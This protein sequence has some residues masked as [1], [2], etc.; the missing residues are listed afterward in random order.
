MLFVDYVHCAYTGN[1]LSMSMSVYVIKSFFSVRQHL[2]L[3]SCAEMEAR[4]FESI[5]RL[6]KIILAQCQ[7]SE[8]KSTG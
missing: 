3:L 6:Y 5:S 4:Q 8:K 1:K 2:S 7:H